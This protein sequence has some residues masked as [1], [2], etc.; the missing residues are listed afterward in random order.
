[1]KPI[2]TAES[3]G[4]PTQMDTGNPPK[5]SY[6]QIPNPL[7]DQKHDMES[8][9][10]KVTAPQ[11]TTEIPEKLTPTIANKTNQNRTNKHRHGEKY[12]ENT[13]SDQYLNRQT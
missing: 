8:D 3:D 4:G 1:M 11:V 2:K 7:L 13:R 9:R 10:E 5:N 12:F 6:R